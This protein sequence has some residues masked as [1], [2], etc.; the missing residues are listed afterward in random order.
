M[1][2]LAL[3]DA[4]HL[5]HR[6]EWNTEFKESKAKI[7]EYVDYVVSAVFA[8]EYRLAIKGNDNFRKKLSPLYK[9]HRVR[10]ADQE[11]RLNALLTYLVKK[12]KAVRAHGMEADDLIAQWHTEAK[13]KQLTVICSVDKDMYTIPGVHYNMRKDEILRVDEGTAN[14]NFCLQLLMG[15]AADAI[16]GVPTIGVVKAKRLLEGTTMANRM[17]AV[18]QVYQTAFK[19]DWKEQLLLNGN[20]LYIRRHPN[21]SFTI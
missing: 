3:I 7:D 15:D 4:D 19:N 10:E 13:D 17:D 16:V 5:V 11:H 14:Y 9:K 2:I 20:L 1:G 18:K 21:D 6:A 8:T 12:Y